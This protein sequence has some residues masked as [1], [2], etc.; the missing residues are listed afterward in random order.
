MEKPPVS[1]DVHDVVHH[2]DGFQHHEQPQVSLEPLF[3][4]GLLSVDSGGLITAWTEQAER[5]F[6]WL[7]GEVIGHPLVATIV[8][9]HHR[10]RYEH[11]LERVLSGEAGSHERRLEV[12]A[13]HRDGREFTIDLVLVPV[14][15]G[16]AFEFSGFLD[17]IGSREWTPETLGHMRG[18]HGAVLEAAAEAYAGGWQEGGGDRLAGALVLFHEPQLGEPIGSEITDHG[19][20]ITDE[21]PP[22][23]EHWAPSTEFQAPS[24]EHHAPEEPE[25]HQPEPTYEPE[26]HEPPAA[27]PEI[28]RTDVQA[29]SPISSER[30]RQTLDEE[31][32]LLSCQPVL[33]LRSNEVAHFEL[34]L[35][36]TDDNGRLVLPQAFLGVAE[37]SG[38]IRAIDRW[39]VRRAIGLVAEQQQM[40]RLVRLELSLSAHSLDDDELPFAIEQDLA[41]TGADPGRLVLGVTEG[42][43]AAAVD[44]TAT[45]VARLKGIGCRFALRD[46]GSNFAAMRHLKQMPLD[47][48]KLDGS[49]IA[50]LTDSRTDQLVLKAIVD[51]AQGIGAD[52]VAE[53]V[54]DEQTLVLLR[55]A[56]VSH[57]Q[58]YHVGPP[59]RVSEAWPTPM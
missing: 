36:M 11:E 10:Q 43:A 59:R 19:S 50:T 56:G 55:Q 18:R 5:S 2:D 25:H 30:L 9:A 46:F 21:G 17:E 27:L 57:A 53:L 37:E 7:R 28:Y 44:V 39:L 32:F 4:A 49:L 45:L 47:Y 38:L 52:T 20:P 58:G 15:L 8:A 14:P 40:G 35:R 23:T 3:G 33:D 26:H 41:A 42:V 12:I 54:S 22:S 34:L 29:P 6:G 51:I 48:L 31:S 1:F 24:T 16:R 13:A